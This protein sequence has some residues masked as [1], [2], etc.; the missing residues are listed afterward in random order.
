MIRWAKLIAGWLLLAWALL[1]F[2]SHLAPT[3]TINARAETNR[4]R[5]VDIAGLLTPFVLTAVGL[6]LILSARRAKKP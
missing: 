4:E 3:P 2:L 5:Y 6:S 1:G